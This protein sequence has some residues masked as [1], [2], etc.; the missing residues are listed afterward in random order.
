MSK[1]LKTPVLILGGG[2]GGVAAALALAERG[3]RCV[4]AEPTVWLGGQLT[5]QAVP[6]DE[7]RWIE[8]ADGVQS[9]TR[10]YL[11]FRRMVREH[12]RANRNLTPSAKGDAMLNPGGGWVSRLCFEP[13]VGLAVLNAMLASHVVSGTIQIM[14]RHSLV[15]AETHGDHVAAVVL[16]DLV[17]GETVEVT[18]EYVLDASETGALY[19]AADIEHAIGAEHRGDYGELHGRADHADPT[20]QQGVTWC[21]AV[22]HRPGETHVIDKPAG[23]D[24]WADFVPT[25]D[26]PWPGPLF[27]WE[28]DGKPPNNRTLAMTPWP[29]EP[30]EGELELWR[31]RRIVDRSIYVRDDAAPPDVS[32]FNCVQMDYFRR[33]TL[34]VSAE[35]HQAALE[36]AKQQSRCFLYW[37]QTAAPRH[38]GEGVGYPGMRLR[39]DELGTDDGFAMAPYIRE[40]RRLIARTMM[41]EAHVGQEQR[42]AE[43]HG[44]ISD[45]VP[46]AG[47]AFAD[48]VGIGHY[49]IDLHPSCA[50]RNSVYIPAAPF[51]VPL[52]ALIPVRVRNVIAAGKALGVTHITNGCTRLHPVEWN[53]G[54]AAG[55]LA[56]TC[57]QNDLEPAE[58]HD[59]QRH[60]RAL[61]ESLAQDG[62]P[63]SWPW[64]DS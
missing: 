36:E 16:R 26:P 20:D 23:Y 47:E 6:P 40:P 31:Y 51:R 49:P 56:A 30:G 7:N 53:V 60:L 13:R 4:I 52:G 22:E 59:T 9:A 54:E 17:E 27:S 18:A 58:V 14:P 5:A 64:E 42:L 24:A 45:E 57:V 3:V 62:V 34:G 55:T 39:G 15:G 41:T 37:L 28:I 33:P 43:G 10:R 11:V 48:S 63:L 50:G 46:V 25:L 35:E 8:G 38:D 1:S 2:V 19:P 12:Y 32:L 44:P 61:Q 21:F 29:D